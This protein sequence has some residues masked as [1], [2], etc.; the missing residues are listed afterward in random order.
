MTARGEAGFTLLELLVAL[1]L[2][3]L[4]T[5]I[6]ASDFHFGLRAWEAGTGSLDD[7]E[8]VQTAQDYLR[9]QLGQ[10]YPLFVRTTAADGYVAFAGDGETMAFLAPLPRQMDTG[11]IRPFR[12]SAPAGRALSVGWS[13]RLFDIGDFPVAS[14]DRETVLLPRTAAVRFAYFGADDERTPPAWRN[15]WLH[16][17]TL[18]RLIRIDVKF[19]DGDRATWPPLVIATA[20]NAVDTECVFDPVSRGCVGRPR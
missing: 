19:A 5:A 4:V 17:R 6:L 1:A 15:D 9:R 13:D 20:V 18:P 14:L 7:S 12:L 3:G 10:I 16:R 8:R 2:L 11:G